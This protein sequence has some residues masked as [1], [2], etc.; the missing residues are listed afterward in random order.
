MQLEIK[1]NKYG[2][3]WGVRAFR[4][5]EKRLDMTTANIL[6]SI[7]D[8]EVITTLAYCALQNWIQNEDESAELPFSVVQFE[9]WLNEQPQEIADKIV[10]DFKN[11]TLN[12]KAILK[13]YDEINEIYASIDSGSEPNK[14]TKKKKLPLPK[15]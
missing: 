10:D 8:G 11:S 13:L 9:N 3:I 15:S 6:L 2:L 12:G 1:G 4:L 14:P 7:S 5:A